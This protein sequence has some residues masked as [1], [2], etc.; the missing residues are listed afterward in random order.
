ML[1]VLSIILAAGRGSRMKGYNKNKTTISLLSNYE[2]PIILEILKNLPPGNKI[3][4]I[5]YRKEDVIHTTNRLKVKYC[6]QPELNGT[7]GAILAAHDLIKDM[8]EKDVVITMGDVPL[9]TRKT[10]YR[11]IEALKN[12][13]LVVLGFKTKDKRQYGL[14]E[15]EGDRVKKIIE[16]NT[17]KDFSKEEKDKY[18]V[19]NSGIY[20]IKKEALLNYI[21]VLSSRPHIVIKKRNGIPTKIKEYFFTDLVEYMDKEGLKIGY[22]TT[23]ER[24]VIG[25][26]DLYSLTQARDIFV[27]KRT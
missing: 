8:K 1:S 27:S 18:E 10:Y 22:V 21:P 6:Q 11:L 24:E 19:C 12:Y 16:W 26:D 2:Y 7:G 23:D 3:I 9:V 17:W 13:D 20:A 25:V 14:L 5:H 4:V 15:V